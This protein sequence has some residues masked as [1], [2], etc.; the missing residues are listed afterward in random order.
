MS[1]DDLPLPPEVF[2]SEKAQAELRKAIDA[3]IRS[4]HPKLWEALR[5]DAKVFSAYRGEFYEFKT[6]IGAW[7]AMARLSWK[8]DAFFGIVLYRLRTRLIV[9]RIPILPRFLHGLCMALYQISI[10]PRVIVRPGLYVPH[11]QIVIDGMVDIA[12]GAV[13]TPWVTIGLVENDVQGPTFGPNVF[14]GTGAKIL[15]PIQVGA[16]AKIGANSV[17]LHDVPPRTTVAGAPAR[18]VAR[19]EPTEPDEKMKA[20]LREKWAKEGRP[21]KKKTGSD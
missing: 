6:L 9:W 2:A 11:G 18:V 7:L 15:G 3:N 21:R 13:L 20:A 14:V 10:G 12:P 17:V 19:A 5:V 1:K 16:R 4:Q 8:S